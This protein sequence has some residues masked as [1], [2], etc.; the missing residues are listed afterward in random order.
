MS[1]RIKNMSVRY[2]RR[3]CR[4]NVRKT[5]N[6]YSPHQQESQPGEV[7]QCL[8]PRR[9]PIKESTSLVPHA[10]K[11]IALPRTS[12]KCRD[13]SMI[14]TISRIGQR[15]LSMSKLV[16]TLVA[17]SQDLGSLHKREFGGGAKLQFLM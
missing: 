14:F 12:A 1:R 15:F 3:N 17:L 13:V 7:P 16:L 11:I 9:K 4:R 10:R 2:Q 6:R 8:I 5:I